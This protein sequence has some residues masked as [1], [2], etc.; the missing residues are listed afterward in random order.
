MWNMDIIITSIKTQCS[1][2]EAKDV[3]V[4]GGYAY[5]AYGADGLKLLDISDLSRITRADAID[6]YNELNQVAI[7]GDYLYAIDSG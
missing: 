2:G 4:K 5:V 6:T 7:F 3:T 1:A